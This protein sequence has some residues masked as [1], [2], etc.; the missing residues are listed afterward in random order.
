MDKIEEYLDKHLPQVTKLGSSG[1]YKIW[2]PVSGEIAHV[3]RAGLT[4]LKDELMMRGL[5]LT[6]KEEVEQRE[7]NNT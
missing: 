3:G 4:K 1:L 2:S 5:K 6:Y 7:G